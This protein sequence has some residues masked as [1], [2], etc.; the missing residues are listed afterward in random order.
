MPIGNRKYLIRDGFVV[1]L[2]LTKGDGSTYTRTYEG[3]EEIALDDDVAALHAHK[4]E[5]ANPKDREAAA[6]AE[7]E[8]RVAEQARSN[9]AELIQQLVAA[10]AQA[11]G[12]AP[13][14]AA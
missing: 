7:A 11:H 5:F 4:L 8:A 14:P 3:G 12:A 10:L 9:P 13:A 6:K 1:V 2:T